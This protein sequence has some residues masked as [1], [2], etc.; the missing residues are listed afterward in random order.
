MYRSTHFGS[1]KSLK[2]GVP[3]IFKSLG[4]VEHVGDHVRRRVGV[5]HHPRAGAEAPDVGERAMEV[6][7][8]FGVDHH[9][10]APGIDVDGGHLVGSNHHEM[11]FERDRDMG[12]DRP[13]DVGTDGEVRHEHA[14]HHI[15]VDP[16]ASRSLE[17][18]TLLPETGEVGG[19]DR[20]ADLDRR[21]HD[22]DT[23][24]PFGAAVPSVALVDSVGAWNSE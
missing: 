7:A 16:V 9:G 4:H 17:G 1:V 2:K 11:G 19:Q 20:W 13:H 24:G 3:G 23:I 12:S 22:A 8:R 10:G 18:D 21:V 5:E 6:G 14:V 15:P